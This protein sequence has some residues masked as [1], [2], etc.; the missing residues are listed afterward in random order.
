[1]R[2]LLL[3]KVPLCVTKW[4]FFYQFNMIDMRGNVLIGSSVVAFPPTV[5]PLLRSLLLAA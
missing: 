4:F 1:M 2:I 5:E 3:I